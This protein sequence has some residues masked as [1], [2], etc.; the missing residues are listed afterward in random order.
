[1]LEGEQEQHQLALAKTE[2]MQLAAER[3]AVAKSVEDVPGADPLTLIEHF[4]GIAELQAVRIRELSEALAGKGDWTLTSGSGEGA[5]SSHDKR[6]RLA[7]GKW[8]RQWAQLEAHVLG[9]QNV[10]LKEDI[11]RLGALFFKFLFIH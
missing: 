8:V 5:A 1:M 6:R 10:N 9:K 7:T 3:N 4:A 11:N 2:R